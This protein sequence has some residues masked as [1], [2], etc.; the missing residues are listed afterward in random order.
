M[1]KLI[2][3]DMD[4]TLFDRPGHVPE[5]TFPLVRALHEHGI[6]F[7]AASGRRLE[8]LAPIFEPVL[9][10]MDFV[11]SNGAEIYAEGVLVGRE[12]FSHEQLLRLGEVV[13]Q[14]DNLHL[15]AHTDVAS[16]CF[17]PPQKFVHMP[18]R[19]TAEA[20]EILR[21]VPGPEVD[22]FNGVIMCEEVEHVP[23]MVYALQVELGDFWTFAWT[24]SRGVD[25]MPKHVSKSNG[26]KKIIRHY[27]LTPDEVMAYGDSMNDYDILRYVGHPVVMGNGLYGV[28]QIAGRIIETNKEHGVQ[29]D[30]ARIL[31]RLER[32]ERQ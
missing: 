32:G 26:I 29:K 20:H 11:C 28:R 23:D 21:E 25:F 7:A 31:E 19:R 30:L 10:V 18:K 14:F 2:A 13:N 12:V 16:Y 22:I 8:E 24:G 9:D 5:E 17:D 4:G 3:S 6:H 15:I 27:L 1:I